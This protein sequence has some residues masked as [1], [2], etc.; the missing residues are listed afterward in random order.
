MKK[1]ITLLSAFV[2]L[3][4]ISLAQEVTEDSY[5]KAVDYLNCKCM[6][7]SLNEDT[8]GKTFNRITNQCREID[9]KSMN[10]FIQKD[11]IPQL[12][13]KLFENIDQ[14]K[15]ETNHSLTKD[16]AIEFLTNKIFERDE[17]KA[18]VNN[19]SDDI[20]R[21]KNELKSYFQNLI[22][23]D[24][25][26]S[27]SHSQ[28]GTVNYSKNDNL[29]SQP[30]SS[31]FL[32]GLSDFLLIICFLMVSFLL[33]KNFTKKN[34]NSNYDSIINRLIESRRMNDHF[35]S[36]NHIF[37]T[38]RPEV[39]KNEIKDIHD[40]IRDLESQ[41]SLLSNKLNDNNK[42]LKENSGSNY[43]Q[44]PTIIAET[45][46][47]FF[48]LSTPNADGSF[49]ESS[50]SL[51]YKGG[52]SI[53]KFKKLSNSKSSF[54]IDDKES[55]VRLALQFPD[56][57][58]DPVCDALNAFN[59]KATKIKTDQPGEAELQNGKWVV[60]KKSKIRYEG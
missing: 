42:S 57:N 12:T 9:N 48:Y 23:T 22:K 54:Q 8:N 45:G 43:N 51:N 60:T 59:P 39:S 37:T 4:N 58:I 49:N 52:A 44:S 27:E 19:H 11:E 17:L 2:I 21:L 38:N 56:K 36:N 30:E 14:F 18:F 28:G 46:T 7:V 1:I 35:K 34:L 5:K 29:E 3:Y 6:E 25:N 40:R 10:E 32:G 41:I 31:G 33:F 50:V 24:S 53:Y 55:S 47:D 15:N 13:K 20:K 26:S 16:S